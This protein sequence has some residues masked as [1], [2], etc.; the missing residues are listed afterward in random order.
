MGLQWLCRQYIRLFPPCMV[1]RLSSVTATRCS[2]RTP[3][4]GSLEAGIFVIAGWRFQD[5]GASPVRRVDCILTYLQLF[6]VL[7]EG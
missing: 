1:K 4:I 3:S 7:D 5:V 6:K 2:T